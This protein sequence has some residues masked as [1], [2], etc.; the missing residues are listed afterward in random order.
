MPRKILERDPIESILPDAAVWDRA[1][2]ELAYEHV[3][4]SITR[5]A[6]TAAAQYDIALSFDVLNPEV[7]RWLEQYSGLMANRVNDTVRETLRMVLSDAI[8]NGE[9]GTA[10][11]DRIMS[12]MNGEANAKRAEMIAR[13]EIARAEHAGRQKQLADAGYTRKV[14]RTNQDAC[15]FCMAL[16]GMTV[17]IEQDFFKR[18]DQIALERED[19]TEDSPALNV[20]KLDYADTPHPPLHPR[21]RCDVDYEGE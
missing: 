9:R 16:E 5:G 18:G 20:L 1:L 17:E 11:R 10:L 13:T 3:K 14:W 15:E 19:S 12:V 8:A 4:N 21:C 7:L 2:A 6:R